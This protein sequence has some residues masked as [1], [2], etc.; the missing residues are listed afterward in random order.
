[1]HRL[2]MSFPTQITRKCEYEDTRNFFLYNTCL[3]CVIGNN[4]TMMHKWI[5][6]FYCNVMFLKRLYSRCKRPHTKY[7]FV[8]DCLH[9]LLFHEFFVIVLQKKEK[10]LLN[11]FV[12]REIV[13]LIGIFILTKSLYIMVCKICLNVWIV[14]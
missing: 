3:L 5:I 4:N 13:V 9:V 1:M 12:F 7:F 10:L 2:Y 8:E 6:S 11:I 14:K